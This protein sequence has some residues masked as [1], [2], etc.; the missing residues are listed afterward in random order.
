MSKGNVAVVGPSAF[1][2]VFEL[3]GVEGFTAEDAEAVMQTVHELL[4]KNEVKLIILPEKFT[5]ETKT[6]RETSQTKSLSPIFVLVPDFTLQT[7]SRLEELR[8]L[9]S[10]AIGAQID[11]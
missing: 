6:L 7:G 4:T 1:N 3:V 5:Q 11:L 2:T 8:T 9:I 10:S